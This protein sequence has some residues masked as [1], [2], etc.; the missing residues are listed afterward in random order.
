MIARAVLRKQM[1]KELTQKNTFGRINKVKLS[2][3]VALRGLKNVSS[4]I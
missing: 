1:K 2:D 4:P 3:L